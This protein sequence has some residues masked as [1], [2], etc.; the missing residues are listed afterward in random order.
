MLSKH[1]LVGSLHT[2]NNVLHELVP[3]QSWRR[4][5][6]ERL[7]RTWSSSGAA[8]RN[9]LVQA[10]L[11]SGDK[12]KAVETLETLIGS[13]LERAD[14]PVLYV[15]AL[16]ELGLLQVDLGEQEEGRRNLERFLEHWGDADWDL[17]EVADARERLG[18]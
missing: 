1:L 14:H 17:P 16:Y 5:A 13:G 15:R 8:F 12:P 4:D 9:G 3:G 6:R 10:Y 18:R 2:S 11:A 7:S